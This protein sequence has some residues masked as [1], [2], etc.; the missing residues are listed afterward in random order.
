[1]ARLPFGTDSTPTLPAS[2]TKFTTCDSAAPYTWN[3]TALSL[4]S[5]ALAAYWTTGAARRLEHAHNVIGTR[6]HLKALL[7]TLGINPTSSSAL[8][9]RHPVATHVIRTALKAEAHNLVTLI[10]E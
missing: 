7:H 10:G 8:F 2:I 3:G 4:S 6:N 1:L 5:D 9:K